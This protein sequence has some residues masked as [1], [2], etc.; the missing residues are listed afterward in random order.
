MLSEILFAASVIVSPVCQWD[1]PG[2][3]RFTGDVSVAVH[4]YI[5][6]PKNIRD[7]LEKRLN[8]K[9]YDDIVDI[10]KDSIIG[11]E[12]YTDLRDMH[13]GKNRVC[14]RVTRDKWTRVSKERGMVYCEENYCIVVPTVC[15]NL[16][17]VARLKNTG[18]IL[19]PGGI[20]ESI[21]SVGITPIILSLSAPIP[22]D[23]F[24]AKSG[25]S[26]APHNGVPQYSIIASPFYYSDTHSWCCHSVVSLPA[27]PEPSTVFLIIIGLFAMGGLKYRRSIDRR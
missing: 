16:S 8:S 27:A 14:Q 11:K 18:W 7:K 25:I 2:A 12:E 3:N 10:T 24:Q 23:S 1:Q 15:G 21:S 4:D 19:P 9:K 6:I 5:D 13:F 22:L 17:R 20:H 26:P